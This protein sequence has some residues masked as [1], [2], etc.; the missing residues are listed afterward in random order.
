MYK[1][2]NILESGK[3]V[4]I[5]ADYL[6]KQDKYSQ[7]GNF[8]CDYC[9]LPVQYVYTG[10]PYGQ[11]PHFR[12]MRV[13][14]INVLERQCPY[15][16]ES[17]GIGWTPAS[18]YK[19][20]G[21]PLVLIRIGEGFE[22]R[23]MFSD[24]ENDVLESLCQQNVLVRNLSGQQREEVKNIVERARQMEVN[25]MVYNLERLLQREKEKSKAEGKVEG[26]AEGKAE[27]KVE[28]IIEVARNMLKRNMAEDVIIDLTGLTRK[29]V[30]ELKEEMKDNVS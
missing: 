5:T 16:C 20:V 22:L 11:S 12:H 17:N 18:V 13:D 2:W 21:L 9:L 29:Q 28:G 30:Q 4:L 27:G 10:N 7:R 25:E 14:D 19:R 23:I 15:Y 6:A 24:I 3:I 26:K 1:A 8:Y